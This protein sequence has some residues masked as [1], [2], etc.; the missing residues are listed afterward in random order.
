ME[1]AP[2]LLRGLDDEA[3]LGD[4]LVLGEGV[5]LD[6]RGEAALRRQAQLLERDVAGGLVD[7]ALE[8]VLALE[9][10]RLRRD[11]PEDDLLA[12]RHEAERLEAA[13]A[14]VVVLEE[15]A[16]DLEPAEEGL[17]D[18]VVA[19]LRR[20]GRLEVAAAEVGRDP[21]ALRAASERG[22]DG[23]DVLLVLGSGSP[24]CSAT[25]ARCLGSLR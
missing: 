9:D 6:G 21:E 7:A 3:Q 4:L 11:E 18:E 8:V 13:G 23:A 5:A 25:R 20:P 19:A 15:E 24:P 2:D 22:V 14:L 12:R 16:I 1:L 10:R 17:G